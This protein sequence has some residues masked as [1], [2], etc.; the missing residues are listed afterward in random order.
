MFLEQFLRLVRPVE[1]F[2][3]G[4]FSGTGVVAAYDQVRTAVVLAN[5][6]VPDGL[7]WSA[8]AHG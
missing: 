8:H 6:A 1:W 2:A 7:A 5:D 3:V 4:I